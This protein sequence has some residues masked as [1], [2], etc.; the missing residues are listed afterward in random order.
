[1]EFRKDQVVVNRMRYR[2]IGLGSISFG[3]LLVLKKSFGIHWMVSY[4]ATLRNSDS[5][6]FLHFRS[7]SSIV[8]CTGIVD[9]PNHLGRSAVKK[10]TLPVSL[11]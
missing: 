1:M 2:F 6:F 10:Y 8:L 7:P 11:T 4:S 5:H 3:C 9:Y